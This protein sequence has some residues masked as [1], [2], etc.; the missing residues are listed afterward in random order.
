MFLPANAA[1][2]VDQIELSFNADGL[3]VLN[4]ILGLVMLGVALDLKPDDFRRAFRRPRG[5]LIGLTAQF[6]LLPAATFGLTRLLNP[7]PSMALGMIL[8][9]SCPGG[10]I[11]NF[12]THLAKGRT[13]L[14]VTMTAIS[15]AF[16]I[17]MTPLNLSFWGSMHP[18]TQALLSEI[19]LDPWEML[20]TV[21]MLLGVP[22]VVGMTLAARAPKLAAWLRKPAKVLSIGFFL[23]FVV[24]AFGANFKHFIACIS[25]VFLPVLLHNATA[26]A[27]GYGCSRGA[28]LT[29]PE[30][31]AVAIEVGIQNSG[32]ALILIFNFFDGLGGMAIIAAWWG[33]WHIIAGLSIAFLWSRRVPDPLP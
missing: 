27:L 9:A 5:P 7:P 21:G 12:L 26:L 30:S 8:V 28:G 16:A 2:A 17:F 25:I 1:H 24:V 23:V 15:T 18:D 13:E 14:S 4:I 20:I 19:Q 29:D 31:R 33:I 11:S 22:V 10:N 6:L 32:L 3:F